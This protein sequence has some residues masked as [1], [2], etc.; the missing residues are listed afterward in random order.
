MP[1]RNAWVSTRRSR[2]TS[3]ASAN[4]RWPRPTPF[5]FGSDWRQSIDLAMNQERDWV[6]RIAEFSQ[7]VRVGSLV[8]VGVGA[9]AVWLVS[10]DSDAL[11][12]GGFVSPL[13]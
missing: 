2:G 3:V 12:V 6:D 5:P 10:G 11:I 7:D 9:I 4:R 1:D 13:A 8:L